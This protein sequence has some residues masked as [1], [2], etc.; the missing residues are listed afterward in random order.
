MGFLRSLLENVFKVRPDETR[1]TLLSFVYLFATIGAFIIARITRTVLFLEIPDYR[2][3]LPLT[4]IGVAISV[5]AVMY[6]YARFERKLRRDWTNGIT[7]AIIIVLTLGIRALLYWPW[8]KPFLLNNSK[9]EVYWI[10]YLWVEVLGTILIVQF[11]T[12]T[13]EIFNSRQGKRLFAIIGGGGVLANVAVGAAIRSTVRVLGTENLLFVMCGSLSLA[14][15]ALILLGRNARAPLTEAHERA[16]PR[17]SKGT[18]KTAAGEKVFSMRHVQLMAAVIVLTYVVSTM[19]D[20]QFNVVVGES[21]AGKDERSAYYAAF[22]LYT[23]LIG[24]AIQFF[25]TARILAR[26]GVLFALLL[27][28]GFMLIGST[29]MALV[30]VMGFIGLWMGALTK[31]SENVLR[32]TINDSTLQLLYL[33]VPSHIRGRAK[34]L[35][36]GI[37][38]PVSVGGAGF[39]MALLVGKLEKILGLSLGFTLGLYE[40]AWLVCG[41]LVCWI[42]TLQLLRREYMKSLVK[43]LQRRRLNFADAKFNI[44]EEGTIKTLLSTLESESVGQ[45]LHAL[46]LLHHV[47]RKAAAAVNDQVAR[48]LGHESEELRVEALRYLGKRDTLHAEEVEVLLMDASPDVRA[49]ATWTYCAMLREKAIA[50]AEHMLEDYDKKVQAAAMAG[51]IRF[52]GLDGV[53]SCADRLKRWLGS[54]HPEDRAQAAYVLGEVGVE[55]FY[56][57][58]IPL[59]NDESEFVRLAAIVAAGKLRNKELI[60]PL[61]EQLGR[62]RL[63]SAAVGALVAYGADIED[64]I[65]ALLSDGERPGEV[66]MQACKILARLGDRQAVKIL[67]EHLAE[68]DSRVRNASASALAS[69]LSRM[70]GTSIDLSVVEKAIREEARLWFETVTLAVDLRLSEESE[71]L[72]DALTHRRQLAQRQIITLLGLKYPSETIDLVA[73]NLRSNHAATK[74][75]AVEVLDNLLGKEEKIFLLPIFDDLSAE[76]SAQAG[77]EVFGIRRR[78]RAFRLRALLDGRDPWLQV[79][80]AL[81]VGRAKIKELEPNVRELLRSPEPVCRETAVVALR[82]LLS[83]KKLKEEVAVLR[84]DQALNV[85]AFATFVLAGF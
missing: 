76:R 78:S 68:E 4:Y 14:L 82:E 25:L 46:E 40:L 49:S 48:L 67:T 20:Y 43:T 69:V 52:G 2:E 21:I 62:P 29:G 54:E 34:A 75:N 31:G 15:V 11:W 10:F 33:P 81:E 27:L 80:S 61:I 64:L 7:L 70:P 85:R 6:W 59:L 44:T 26:F 51:L 18:S 73:R 50:K 37:F 16:V 3:Q 53:L 83:S 19:V 55:T 28:P 8:E 72:S 12:I 66:R 23:G 47:P 24:G 41:A 38:K 60:D 77:V 58:L 65:G 45:V 36:D 57:P 32:Y 79:C 56:S 84:D 17:R 22:F 5:S 13:N 9:H 30:P 71:L 39:V 74:A 42:I 63:R 35:I 1:R